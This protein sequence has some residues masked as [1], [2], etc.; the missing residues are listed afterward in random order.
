M[1][2]ATHPST[3]ADRELVF[4]RILNAPPALAFQAWTH[5]NHVAKWWGPNGF[6]I[7]TE[8]MD[9]RVSGEWRFMMHGP[10]GMDFPNKITFAEV[11][12]P[13][14]LRYRHGDYDDAGIFDVTVT[15][16]DEGGRTKLTMRFVFPTAADKEKVVREFGAIEGANQHLDHLAK[17]LESIGERPEGSLVLTRI[18]NAPRALV[19]EAWTDPK[20]MAQWWGPKNFTNPVCE[21]DA[22]PGGAMRIHMRGPDGAV[23]VMGGTFRDVLKPERLVFTNN[24][25]DEAGN[26]LLEGLTTVTF[27]EEAN[28][29]KLTID[30]RVVGK[31]AIAPAMIAGMEVGWTQSLERLEAFTAQ[32]QGSSR[33]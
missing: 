22:R 10:N 11:T 20:H 32:L 1:A 4:T 9:V 8:S 30:T 16:E 7:T 3:T 26:T 24:A 21:V 14:R 25:Y 12:P 29:T 27:V 28:R 18:V 13:S 6:T 31:A 17:H 23:H 2:T 5:P 19:W 15:F 33:V